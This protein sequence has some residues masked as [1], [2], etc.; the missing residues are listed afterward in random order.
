V[1][2]SLG[3]SLRRVRRAVLRRR[4]LLAFVLAALAAGLVVHA[5][6][7]TP[8]A[9][10]TLTVAAHDLAAGTV[11]TAGDLTARGVPPGD[12][13]DGAQASPVG[14]VL[15][16]PLRRGEPVTDARLVGPD[17]TAAD[18]RLVALPVRLSDAEMAGLLHV[19][20]RL[21]LLATSTT[22]GSTRTV[23]DDV[24]V[25]ALPQQTLDQSHVMPG[26]E[27]RLVIVGVS[28]DLV[29]SLTSAGVGGFLTFAWAH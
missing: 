12:V 24:R 10:V 20:D 6:R 25:L 11:L 9:A 29:T 28:D 27:G 19:G 1:L 3:S 23:A 5:A 18:P 4:R 21:R 2:T 14:A 8:P 16:A 17:L 7:P 26:Q 15:A 13:P 22:T